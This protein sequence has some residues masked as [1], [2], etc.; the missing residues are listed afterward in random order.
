MVVCEY[1]ACLGSESSGQMTVSSSKVC[2]IRGGS[3]ILCFEIPFRLPVMIRRFLTMMRGIVMMAR[4][5]MLTG[6][7]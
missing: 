3:W 7:A 1:F 4:G 6:H 5:G 2:M